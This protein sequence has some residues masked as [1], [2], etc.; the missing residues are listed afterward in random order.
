MPPAEPDRTATRVRSLAAHDSSDTQDRAAA[1]HDGRR[2]RGAGLR[3]SVRRIRSAPVGDQEGLPYVYNIDEAGHFVPK[4]VTMFS[5]GLNPRYFVNPPALT[6]VLHFVLDAWFGG[7][8]GSREYAPPPWRGVPCRAGH[9][10]YP[11]NCGGV[12][13]LSARSPTV[14][15]PPR[16]ARGRDRGCGVP[17]GS[18][19]H[20]ALNDATTLLPLTL[21]LFGSA[22]VMRMEEG[23]TMRSPGSGF[24]WRAQASTRP[25]PR[26]CRSPSPPPL[27]TWIRCDAT[28]SA[29]T[30]RGWRRVVLGVALAGGCALVSFLA[31][32]P[33]RA[34]GFQTVPHRT[35][36]TNRVSPTKHRASSARPRRAGSS[37][38]CGR[39]R[40]ASAG[41]RRWLRS[42]GR[43]RSG[44]ATVR[45][46]W[47]LVPAAVLFLGFM[48]LQDRYFG[49][50]LLLIFPIALRARR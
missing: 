7:A 8:H 17:A 48:G 5:D 35:D 27:T 29:A 49:R 50:W 24:A 25:A 28:P 34:A 31:R 40:G 10:R 11:G 42:E 45:T 41:Y 16:P 44:E 13:A 32:K 9:G 20:F 47:L 37:T 6:Y 4:A 22:G 43:S 19:G 46:G 3:L 36:H 26:S 39:S 18:Y 2:G 33:L 12:D 1:D 14:R 30:P 38:T 15:S 21:S 23:A